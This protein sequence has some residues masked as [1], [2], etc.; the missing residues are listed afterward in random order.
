MKIKKYSILAIIIILT[1]FLPIGKSFAVETKSLTIQ[2]YGEDITIS[3]FRKE[4]TNFKKA[5]HDK[6]TY[7]IRYEDNQKGYLV[8]ETYQLDNNDIYYCV[9]VEGEGDIPSNITISL[10][11]P[12]KKD[13]EYSYFTYPLGISNKTSILKE[14]INSKNKKLNIAHTAYIKRDTF[15]MVA[16]QINAYEEIK[17]EVIK[18]DVLQSTYI[19]IDNGKI[20]G[21]VFVKRNYIVEMWGIVSKNQLVDMSEKEQF[22]AIKI[23]DLSQYRKWTMKGPYYITPSSYYPN[24]ENYFY[25]NVAQHIGAMFLNTKGRFFQDMATISIYTALLNQNELGIWYTTP[26]STWLYEDYKIGHYF[27]DTRFNSDAALF[28]INGYREFNDITMLKGAI[29]YGDFLI[30]YIKNHHYNTIKDG[31]LVWDYGDAFLLEN[32]THV[33]LNHLVNEMNFLYELYIETNKKEYLLMGNKIKIA[34]DDTYIKW[35]KPNNDLW[36]AY[37][38]DGSFDLKDY[39]NLTLRDLL[40]SQ[41]LIMKI[42]GKKDKAF[43]VLITKKT[44]YLNN[45][46]LPLTK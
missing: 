6:T 28:L 7:T 12:V 5:I 45:Y 13:Y 32:P 4:H 34:V 27:Y 29:K 3:L 10:S 33:S 46:K 2:A 35:S 18:D 39:I 14:N 31:Y 15:S 22:E 38:Q 44:Q 42:Q 41:Q 23:A 17:N 16:S 40:Y 26:K 9:K 1:I 30:E 25:N 19:S 20:T 21:K 36:Y 8:F 37:M 43:E 11:L 24:K